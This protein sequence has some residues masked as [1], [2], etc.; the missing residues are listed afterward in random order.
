MPSLIIEGE[1]PADLSPFTTYQVYNV[2]DSAVTAQLFPVMHSKLNANHLTVYEREMRLQSL[3]L[4]LSSKG[5]PINQMSLAE[6]L[7]ALEKRTKRATDVL[8]RFCAAIDF[9]PLNP[10]SPK[11]VADLF[12]SHLNLQPIYEYDR[13]NDRRRLA[14]DVKALEKLRAQYPIAAPFVNAILEAKQSN[15]M[16]SVFKRGLEPKTGNLRCSFGMGTETGRLNSF[17]NPYG[18]GTNGQNLTDEIRQVISAPDGYV[19]VNADLKTAESIAVG[20][21]SADR[22]YIDAC[23]SGDLHTAVA[24]LN[25][26]ELP[27]TGNLA[28]DRAI[29]EQIYYRHF[30][31]RDMA[32][33]GGHGTNYYGTARTMAM[34]LKLTTA[35][36]QAFQDAYFAAFPGIAAWHLAIIAQIQ[37]TGVL[38]T[39]M[40][41]ERRFWGRP[42][43]PATHREAIAYGPQSLVAD[44]WNEGLMQLQRW[45]IAQ[46]DSGVQL[47]RL[48]DNR[49]QVH[50]SGVFLLPLDAVHDLIPIMRRE[51]SYPVDFGDLGTMT[52]PVDFTIGK[53][54]NKKP[55]GTATRW[56]ALGQRDYSPDMD[57]SIFA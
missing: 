32:K 31:Y 51:L 13:K 18:R 24:K 41:R 15:K 1:I 5:F 47:A 17:Q 10:N 34:H 37:Q 55:K 46:R 36:V 4:E 54:W 30:T 38:T 53:T 28:E 25:W 2:L 19:I 56:N 42:D 49:A 45:I 11:Q 50:D 52:I 57:L 40:G 16:A 26:P 23:L 44:L 35:I 9:G 3:C 12:Y 43:D 33:R 20:F 14:T 21:L 22:G 48:P 8:Q 6:L 7:W 39:P 29:A 27:W